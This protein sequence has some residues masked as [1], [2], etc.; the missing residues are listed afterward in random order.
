MLRQLEISGRPRLQEE[1][2]H[3]QELLGLLASIEEPWKPDMVVV[4][5]DIG[6]AGKDEDYAE[7]EVWLHQLLHAVRLTPET[8][9]VCPGNHD[10][11][12]VVAPPTRPSDFSGADSLLAI[13][14]LHE[15]QAGFKAFD[16]FCRRFG[17][18]KLAVGSHPH[19]LTGFGKIGPIR[20][21]VLNSAWFCR[22]PDDSGKLWLGLPLL[23]V[24]AATAQL[25]R[26]AD[27]DENEVSIAIIHHPKEWLSEDEYIGYGNR[28]NTYGYLS[29][30]SHMILS[31]HVH[32]RVELPDRVFNNAYLFTGG[33]VY[34]SDAY[35]NNFSLLKVNPERR[36]LTRRAWEY[37]PGHSMWTEA[38]QD[39]PISLHSADY[40]ATLLA[41]QALRFDLASMADDY[42]R[43]ARANLAPLA[44][45]IA[46]R[47]STDIS[48]L[49]PEQQ[50]LYEEYK[51]RMDI[52]SSLASL[53]REICTRL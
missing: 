22:G 42:D 50:Q 17:V 29:E 25:V 47:I 34:Q 27:L 46:S 36:L 8:V 30:R 9:I 35:R 45:T 33:A 52:V 53:L 19:C 6:W 41:K 32:G 38:R 37:D 10:I 1:K 5:G 24:M 40:V 15:Q 26:I 51:S 14:N 49:T 23:D 16:A 13:E 20:F 18:T 39:A 4:S 28:R 2:I 31:G 48:L 12:R 3:Y 44:T 7:A 21:T 43:F 11:D